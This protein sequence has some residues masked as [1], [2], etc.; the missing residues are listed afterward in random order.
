MQK[1]AYILKLKFL[2]KMNLE[3]IHVYQ[4]MTANVGAFV[5]IMLL[6]SPSIRS[7]RILIQF[8]TLL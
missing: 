6:I 1:N 4:L 8:T 5:Q 3:Y 7:N 2:F